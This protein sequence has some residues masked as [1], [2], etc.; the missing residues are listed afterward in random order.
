MLV[1]RSLPD[2]RPNEIKIMP[3]SLII[4]SA[5]VTG[6]S[7]WPWTVTPVAS[8]PNRFPWP[9]I[10]IVTPSY[11][12]G[13]FLEETIRSVLLQGY[14]NLEYIVIDGGSTDNSLD[15]IRKYEKHLAYWHSEKDEGQTDAIATGFDKS[16]GE[17]LAW[18]NSD[19]ILLPGALLHIGKV[20]T[21]NPRAGVVFGNTL[22]IDSNSNEIN[23]Y[24]WPAQLFKYHWSLGQYIGQES[25]F[26]RRDVYNRVG[27]LNR[28]KFFVMDYD[29]FIRMWKVS[30]FKK[31]RRFIGG[32][33][34]HEDSKNSKHQDVRVNELNEAKE[35]YGVKELGYFGRRVA[36]RVDRVQ[37]Y[38]ERLLFSFETSSEAATPML[39]SPSSSVRT[40]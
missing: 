26:W 29:L 39:L 33:R 4:P 12:Q 30:R 6:K 34:V 14:P 5:A 2:R 8:V 15:I 13:Q 38:L 22:V 20:F 37:N 11:N 10:S 3:G 36:N 32:F 1:I 21:K 7:G 19:D 31:V 25:C 24:F 27:G 18:L 9:K 40:K 35:K 16:S 23:R 28:N 17:I